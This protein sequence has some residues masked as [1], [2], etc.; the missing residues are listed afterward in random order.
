MLISLSL[1]NKP[2]CV[3]ILLE[4]QRGE[5]YGNEKDTQ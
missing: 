3:I 1:Q 2:I 5:K 4:T